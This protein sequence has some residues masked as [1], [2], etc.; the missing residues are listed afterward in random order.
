MASSVSLKTK[1]TLVVPLVATVLLLGSMVVVQV[2]VKRHLKQSV[3]E[4]QQQITSLVAHDLDREF[5]NAL[6]VLKTLAAKIPPADVLDPPKILSLLTTQSSHINIFTNGLFLFGAD[7]R[8]IAE[9]PLGLSRSGSDFS[10]R[11]YL[12]Q[13][14]SRKRPYISDPYISSQTH[15][16]PVLM[17][18][19]PILGNDGSVRAVLGGSVDLTKP[20]FLGKLDQIRIGKSGYLSVIT[21]ERKLVFHPDKN[22]IMQYAL[23]EGYGHLLDKAIAGFQGTGETTIGGQSV[24]ATYR[25]LAT[26]N[27]LI[28]ASSPLAESLTPLTRVNSMIMMVLIPLA[29]LMGLLLHKALYRL[30]SPILSLVAHVQTFQEKR[31][32]QRLVPVSGTDEVAQL[33]QAFNTLVTEIDARQNK[34]AERELLYRT[35]VDFSSEMVFWVSSDH[36]KMNYVSP[37]CQDLTGYSTEEF[38]NRPQLLEEMIHP[39][40]R[41]HWQDHFGQV[42]DAD[43]SEALEFRIVTKQGEIRWVNHFCRPV[44]NQEDEFVGIRGSFSDVTLWKHA[45]IAIMASEE[46][47]RLFFEESS[48]VILILNDHGIIKEVNQETCNRY[49]FSRGELQ[50]KHL[51][52]METPEFACGSSQHIAQIVELGE[53]TFESEHRCKDGNSLPVEVKG[54]LIRYEGEQV[55]LAVARDIHDRKEADRVLHRH[56]EYLQALHEMTLGLI[57]RLDVGSLLQAVASRAGKL[58]GTDNSYIYLRNDATNSLDM[59]YQSGIY[60]SVVRRSIGMHEGVAGH[61]IATGE[62][63]CVEN[64]SLWEGRLPDEDRNVLRAMAGVPLTSAGEVIGVLGLSFLED[65]R[66]FNDDQMSVLKQFGELAALALINAQ[67]YADAQNELQERKKIE[68]VLR[69][70]SVVVEQ[71]PLSII[72]TDINGIIEYVNPYFTVITGYDESEVIGQTPRI[73]KSG[74]TSEREY[75]ELWKTIL[76]GHEWRGEFHNI[77]KNGDPYWE[78]A[79]IAPLRNEQGVLTHFIAIKEDVTEQKRLASQL[80]HSQKMEA[81]GQLAGGI[82]HDFNNI[83]TAVIGYASLIQLKLSPEDVFR[84]G[85]DQILAAAERG[86]SLT[87]GLLA[88]SR[89]RVTNPRLADLNEVIRR[90]EKLLIRLIGEDICLKSDLSPQPLMVMV[91]SI[92]IEQVLMNLATNARDAMPGGGVITIA[93]ER[94]SLEHAFVAAHGFGHPGNYARIGFSDTGEGIDAETAKRIFEPFFSTKEVGKGTGLGLSITYG[95]IKEHNGIIVCDSK[96]GA[97]TTFS[98]YLPVA[99]EEEIEAEPPVQDLGYESGNELI[100]LAEDNDTARMLSREI[101]EDFGYLVIEARDGEEALACYT[102][103]ADEINLLILDIIMPKMKGSDVYEK[104]RS[105]NPRQKVLF[106][107]GY[108]EEL[109]SRQGLSGNEVQILSKPFMPKELLIKIREVL[110]NDES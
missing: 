97:G 52:E 48:D 14:L 49:G 78:K 87:Q 23:P 47:F 42:G 39:E 65:D 105:I 62:P 19:A 21:P 13:T 30:T 32:E 107:S 58:V 100:L 109:L 108:A 9:L 71:S 40:D 56:N 34:L 69:K 81:V 68:D 17:F 96:K 29:L 38:Y 55:I 7:G 63:V 104:I 88:F 12:Q 5:T 3:T 18:T 37:S 102:E 85:I 54:R 16:H 73:L 91:D 27:W 66:H 110:D 35:V 93:T 74:M 25:K 67:L 77:K 50:G 15:H 51:A 36:L 31:G 106:C 33:S 57:S 53:A 59:V 1:V 79:L 8:M 41:P 60:N 101:L 46:K 64:Y 92:Q 83:L 99:R 28:I 84:N 22:R 90:V 43:F 103:R 10:Y 11:D 24:L 86:A 20:V 95:V 98:M 82:A 2:V 72:I 45:E 26:T 94:V 89:Q 75:Q 70:L 61:V 80:R 44:Q 6:E 4:Q 76:A